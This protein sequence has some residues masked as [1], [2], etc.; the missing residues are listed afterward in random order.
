[1]IGLRTQVLPDRTGDRFLV[2]GDHPRS[3]LPGALVLER[4]VR[5]T[6]FSSG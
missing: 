4:V 3:G 1:M 5:Q 6:D 2:T